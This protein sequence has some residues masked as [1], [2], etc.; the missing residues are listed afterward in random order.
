MKFSANKCNRDDKKNSI[1]V[2][3]GN[4]TTTAFHY[5]W[6]RDNCRCPECYHSISYQRQVDTA[7]ISHN[8]QPRRV[9]VLENEQLCIH[10]ENEGVVETHTSI[11]SS[12]WLMSCLNNDLEKC[13]RLVQ[14]FFGQPRAHHDP[15]NTKECSGMWRQ[16][17]RGRL[18]FLR[19]ILRQWRVGMRVYQNGLS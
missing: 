9:E 13:T 4:N 19:L 15:G 12:N 10:W 16:S 14:K 2:E 8:L 17:N 6:L 3:W 5:F 18:R 7:R 1:I 11:F